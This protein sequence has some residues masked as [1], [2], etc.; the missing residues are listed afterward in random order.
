MIDPRAPSDDPEPV[1]GVVYGYRWW[2]LGP[3]GTLTSPWRAPNRWRRGRNR[4]RCLDRRIHL[5][6]RWRA[7]EDAHEGHVPERRCGCGFYGLWAPSQPIVYGR[8]LMVWDLDVATSG[9]FGLVFGV[10]AASGRIILGTDGFRAEHAE[11]VAVATGRDVPPSPAWDALVDR[12]DVDADEDTG[13]LIRRWR[14]R[15]GSSQRLVHSG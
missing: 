3:D 2:R 5:R 6:R 4:A 10:I 11:V 13:E 14:G 15:V 8:V 7:V 9:A 12:Y 1:V